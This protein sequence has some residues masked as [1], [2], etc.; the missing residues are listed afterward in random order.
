MTDKIMKTRDLVTKV[1][2][3]QVINTVINCNNVSCFSLNLLNLFRQCVI[4]G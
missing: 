3:S 1:A 4:Y 2:K